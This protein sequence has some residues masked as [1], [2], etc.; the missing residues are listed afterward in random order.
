MTWRQLSDEM[1]RIL[2]VSVVPELRSRGFKGSFPHFR[3]ICPDRIDLL[4]FQFSQFGPDL[5][6]EVGSCPSNGAT[7]ADGSHTPP[8]KVCTHHAG[9]FRRRIGP[10]PSVDFGKAIDASKSGELASLVLRAI[11]L[12][13]ETWWS[14]P[15]SIVAT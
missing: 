9:Y 10:Q 12:E 13:G 1:R 5:Y 15:K 6:I 4:T 3:R 8:S 11:T 7:H 14:A 2:R